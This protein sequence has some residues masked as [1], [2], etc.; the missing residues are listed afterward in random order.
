M[1]LQ[2][3]ISASIFNLE[4]AFYPDRF[5]RN[6]PISKRTRRHIPE[7]LVLITSNDNSEP[8][9]KDIFFRVVGVE[10][11]SCCFQRHFGSSWVTIFPVDVA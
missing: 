4:E 6:V 10:N 8:L 2:S 5:P 7:N 1:D 11:G 3:E 9:N